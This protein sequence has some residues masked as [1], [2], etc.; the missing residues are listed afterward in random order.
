MRDKRIIVMLY[1]KANYSIDVDIKS[2]LNLWARNI[3]LNA[4]FHNVSSDELRQYCS[5]QLRVLD[6][7]PRKILKSKES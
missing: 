7:K 3:L 6:P 1:K 4:G 2:D 5:L